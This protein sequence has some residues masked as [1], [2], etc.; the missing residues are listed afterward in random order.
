MTQETY[1]RH[2]YIKEVKGMGRGVFC[3]VDIKKGDVIEISPAMILS[4]GDY[5]LAQNTIL[6]QYVYECD[7]ILDHSALA[8]GFGSLFNHADEPNAEF[9]ALFYEK[10]V[11][12]TAI[13]DIPAGEQIFV[14]YGWDLDDD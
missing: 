14:D 7:D 4:P 5:H 10:R 2:L 3:E 8:F 9:E 11:V 12:F 1:S 13:Q 6:N